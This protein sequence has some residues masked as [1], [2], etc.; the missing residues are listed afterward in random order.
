[1]VFVT[2]SSAKEARVIAQAVLKAKL[3]ACVNIVPGIESHYWWRGRLDHAREHL[4]VIKS[5][6]R[7]FAKLAALV[8]KTHSYQTPEIIAVPLSASEAN[9]ARWWRESLD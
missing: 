6:R 4:L 5:A 8:K 7:H 1:V 9:Y 3:A 2:A